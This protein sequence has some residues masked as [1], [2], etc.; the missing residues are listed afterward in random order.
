MRILITRRGRYYSLTVDD[1]V[2]LRTSCLSIARHHAGLAGSS[3]GPYRIQLDGKNT[4][5]RG[6]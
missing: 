1:C 6:Q 2:V 3:E 4:Q 5:Q